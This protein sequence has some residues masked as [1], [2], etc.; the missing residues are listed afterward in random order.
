MVQH[1]L[2]SKTMRMHKPT[3]GHQN[4]LMPL[5]ALATPTTLVAT[6]LR[7]KTITTLP[8]KQILQVQT[9]QPINVHL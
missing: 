9:T 1:A 8:Q 5:I 7:P 3:R 6:L 4:M 2:L